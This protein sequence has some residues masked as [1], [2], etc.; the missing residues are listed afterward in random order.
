MF[1]V[2]VFRDMTP[3]MENQTGRKMESDMDSWDCIVVDRDQG[4]MKLGILFFRCLHNG[5][6]ATLSLPLGPPNYGLLQ[7]VKVMP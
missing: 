7:H 3:M 2:K 5:K 6:S 4:F 1:R